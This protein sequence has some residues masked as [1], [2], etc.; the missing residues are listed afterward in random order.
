MGHGYDETGEKGVLLVELEEQATADF[1]ALDTPRFYDLEAPVLTTAKEAIAAVLPGGGSED[2]YRVT[3]TG[4][5]DKPDLT[6]LRGQ[7]DRYPNL[8]LRDKTRPAV[9]VWSAVGE[10]S[11]EGMY[12]RILRD[13]MEGQD[14]ESRGIACLAARIS[15]TI[16]DGG[17]VELP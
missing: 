5:C 6:L 10:D 3:L 15:R 9:D 12:F 1:L 17:E 4:E 7:F 13:A 11:L 16:L 2:F 14:E 8:E